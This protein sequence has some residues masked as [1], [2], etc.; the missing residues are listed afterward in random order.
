MQ[1]ILFIW[2]YS[3][4]WT[5]ASFPP[6]DSHKPA[7]EGPVKKP[8]LGSLSICP[9]VDQSHEHQDPLEWE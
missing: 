2:N 4:I 1:E 6:I 7:Y 3:F 5:F 9:V 8:Y